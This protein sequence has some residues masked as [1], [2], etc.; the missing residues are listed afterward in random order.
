MPLSN[1]I[2]KKI[3]KEKIKNDPYNRITLSFYRYF[4][5]PSPQNFR[6]DWYVKL[7][8]LKV[9]GRIYKATEGI[10]GQISVPELNWV[11]F[12][13]F[14]ENYP[15]LNEMRL[16]IAVEQNFSF[17]M[18]KVKT[19]HKI[20]ADGLEENE[21][22]LSNKGE[23]LDAEKFNKLTSDPDTILVDMRNH[24]ESE[25]GHFQNAICPD[26]DTFRDALPFVRNMLESKKD[27]PVV[28]YCT[29]GIRCE[30]ASA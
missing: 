22:D 5:I 10:N 30:K 9:Y 6:D 15:E 14:L 18:L 11:A 20:V 23:Y 1:L 3:L 28:M 25:V 21:I 12:K 16:N 2:N 26:V 29:G 4:K 17:Y 8:S 24:Y 7:E 27:Q 19:R 13:R